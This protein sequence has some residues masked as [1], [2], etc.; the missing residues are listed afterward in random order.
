LRQLQRDLLPKNER[1]GVEPPLVHSCLSAVLPK[2]LRS[3]LSVILRH[4]A[5]YEPETSRRRAVAPRSGGVAHPVEQQA[6]VGG[7]GWR[8][9]RFDDDA[10]FDRG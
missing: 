10:D 4:G 6:P 1:G 8:Y 7:K 5:L 2:I 3:L 9:V